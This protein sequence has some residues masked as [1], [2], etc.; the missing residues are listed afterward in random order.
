ML[1]T[2]PTID[3][4]VTREHC[5]CTVARSIFKGLEVDIAQRL[6]IDHRIHAASVG[7]G[8][9]AHH[10]LDYCGNAFLLH[11]LRPGPTQLCNQQRVF[12]EQFKCSTG[13]RAAH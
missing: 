3:P 5:P 10:V 7:F 2:R 1:G 9:I 11:A 4:V 13:Q 8:V 6:F 12:A